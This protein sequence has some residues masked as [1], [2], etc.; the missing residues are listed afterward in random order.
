[1]TSYVTKN[2][3]FPWRLKLC[4]V[5]LVFTP[6]HS[7]EESF[8]KYQLSWRA[9]PFLCGRLIICVFS[10]LLWRAV[11]RRRDPPCGETPARFCEPASFTICSFVGSRVRNV[12]VGAGISVTRGSFDA[13]FLQKQNGKVLGKLIVHHSLVVISMALAVR[14]TLFFLSG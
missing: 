11:R 3:E 7:I 14:H 5:F 8:Y 9:E 13:I 12:E 2:T 4:L 10:V 6:Q 1:M